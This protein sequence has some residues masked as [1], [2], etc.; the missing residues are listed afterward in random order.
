M[1]NTTIAEKPVVFV[2]IVLVH[3]LGKQATIGRQEVRIPG[4]LHRLT[5]RDFFQDRTSFGWPGDKPTGVWTEHPLARQICTR[6]AHHRTHRADVSLTQHAWLM[7]AHFSVSKTTCHPSVMSHMLPHLPQNTSTRSL[8]PTSPA[9]RPSS[10]SL[11]CPTSVNSGLDLKPCETHGG[12]TKSASPTGYEP[13]ITQSDNLEA[14]R[15]ELD[16]NLGTSLQP[17]RLK[18]DQ[19]IGTDPYQILERIVGND[20]QNPFT[21]DTEETGNCRHAL[22]P[23]QDT[24]RLRFS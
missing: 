15:I 10:P 20:C 12:Y 8:S 11:S 24:L 17:R 14:R 9:F 21:E 2:A 19:N 13:Q 4:I 18:L 23:I 3:K 6:T 16:R 5:I 1:K 7:I 22:R